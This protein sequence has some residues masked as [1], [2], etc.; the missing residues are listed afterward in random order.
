MRTV[1][2]VMDMQMELVAPEAPTPLAQQARERDIVAR[3][4]RAIADAEAEEM[5]GIA[6]TES[7]ESAG[8]DAAA[9]LD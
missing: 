8:D 2:L 9:A 6:E 4:R 3:T 5:A 1:Y 7:V